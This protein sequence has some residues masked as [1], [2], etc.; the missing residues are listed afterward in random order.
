VVRPGDDAR[1]VCSASGAQPMALA[2]TK[3]DSQRMSA[4]VDVR[5]GVLLFRRIS[6]S[7]QGKYVC[8][9]TNAVGRAEATAEVI[10]Q[11]KQGAQ[12]LVRYT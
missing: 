2:W 6:A 4:S 9:A 8:S 10:V 12:G 7:D 5:D 3:A 11:G 1:I